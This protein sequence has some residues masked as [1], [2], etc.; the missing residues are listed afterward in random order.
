MNIPVLVSKLITMY[1][2]HLADLYSLMQRLFIEGRYLK[3]IAQLNKY[4]CRALKKISRK[5]ILCMIVNKSFIYKSNVILMNLL[6]KK[7]VILNFLDWILI[8]LE[9]KC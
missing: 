2:F 1:N 3:T 5:D 7:F 6:T 4:K 8:F 9:W